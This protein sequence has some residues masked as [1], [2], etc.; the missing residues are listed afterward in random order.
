M[1]LPDGLYDQLLTEA[2]RDAVTRTTDERAHSLQPLTA[3]DAPER[4]ADALAAQLAHSGN[5]PG[6]P[7]ALHRGQ[8]LALAA[9]RAVP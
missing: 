3:E 4:L 2:L 5:R 8:G 6:L 1:T 9:D 7:L